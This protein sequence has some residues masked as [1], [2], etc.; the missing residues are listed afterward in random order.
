MKKDIRRILKM[1]GS[2]GITFPKE[3][4]EKLKANRHINILYGKHLVVIHPETSKKEMI[5]IEEFFDSL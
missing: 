5:K 4:K 1:G 3:Y 2:K